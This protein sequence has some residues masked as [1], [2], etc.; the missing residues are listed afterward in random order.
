MQYS[1]L[2]HPL[3]GCLIIHVLLNAAWIDYLFNPY[4]IVRV[5]MACSLSSYIRPV[6]VRWQ[7]QKGYF[8]CRLPNV[9]QGSIPP[10]RVLIQSLRKLSGGPTSMD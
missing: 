10:G 1:E 6:E 3:S 5:R 4:S 2:I 7:P 8:P 9:S